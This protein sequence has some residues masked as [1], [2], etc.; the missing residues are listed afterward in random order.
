M[1]G[2]G[3]GPLALGDPGVDVVAQPDFALGQFGDRCREVAAVGELVDALA[4]DAE[5]FT[6]LMRAD[7]FAGALRDRAIPATIVIRLL[8]LQLWLE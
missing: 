6:D 4:A 7:P 3:V 2:A 8:V 5:Q 1:S